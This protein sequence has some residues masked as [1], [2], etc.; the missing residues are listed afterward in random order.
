MSH[1]SEA[2]RPALLERLQDNDAV[3]RLAAAALRHPDLV[4]HR[5]AEAHQTIT[6][7]VRALE[8][9]RGAEV[10]TEIVMTLG[11]LGRNEAADLPLV[12][13]ALL[14][15]SQAWH[16]APLRLHSLEALGR[17]AGGEPNKTGPLDAAMGDRLR[18][19]LK[20]ADTTVRRQAVLSLKDVGP[21]A[22]PVLVETVR[23][24]D[25]DVRLLAV[26]S[27]GEMGD[28]SADVLG[29]LRQA[30]KDSDRGVQK[31]AQEALHKLGA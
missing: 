15:A 25:V 27:L 13:A 30:E 14:Q 18:R 26:T 22:V 16:N 6:E 20:D 4:P 24:K 2:V 31:A 23:A 19:G 21:R 1:V 11:L 9:P 7:L 12:R 3:A 29:A 5:P 10:Q 17:L 8:R 28:R